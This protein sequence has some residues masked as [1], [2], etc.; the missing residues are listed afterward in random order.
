M[1]RVCIGIDVS[2]D[3]LDVCVVPGNEYFHVTNNGEGIDKIVSRIRVLKPSKVVMEATGGYGALCAAH[4][5]AHEIPLAVVNPRQVRDFARAMGVLAKTD[6]IDAQVLARF[7][8]A[9]DPPC[10]PLPTSDDREL[11]ELLS[12]RSQLV[13]MR[14][15]ETNRL[16]TTRTQSAIGSIK[17]MLT[18]IN[19]EI[20][21]IDGDI[22]QLIKDS[23][24]WQEK[25]K[26]YK[27]VPSIGD[28]TASLLIAN[29]PEL[30]KLNRREIASLV[31]LAP[32]NRDSGTLRGRRMVCGGRPFVRKALYM[33]T[34]NAIRFNPLIKTMYNRLIHVGKPHKVA[35]TA[36]MRKLLTIVNAIARDNTPWLYQKT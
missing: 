10:R 27:S 33:P 5:A 36:C 6:A 9:V 15:S 13:N 26:L 14:T 28:G 30:G 25:A 7:A 1:E 17:I 21:R 18:T 22:N 31:G 16:R 35:I 2:K 8:E 24:I 12:R 23:P 34:I 4:L 29:L 32:M 20:I 19:E 3:R 11:R